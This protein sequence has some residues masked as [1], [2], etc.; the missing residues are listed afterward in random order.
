MHCRHVQYTAYNNHVKSWKKQHTKQKNNTESSAK[1][2]ISDF[3][4]YNHSTVIFGLFHCVAVYALQN[5]SSLSFAV[6]FFRKKRRKFRFGI[7]LFLF[8]SQTRSR[9][10]PQSSLLF[11]SCLYVSGILSISIAVVGRYSKLNECMDFHYKR[12]LRFHCFFF[13]FLR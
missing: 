6:A 12:R 10:L 5:S 4:P 2:K 3:I 1:D 7:V 11:H 9:I 13:C 8:A